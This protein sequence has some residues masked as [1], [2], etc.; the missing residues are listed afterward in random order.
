MGV[1]R[2]ILKN[3][4]DSSDLLWKIKTGAL[5]GHFFWRHFY[6]PVRVEFCVPVPLCILFYNSR[7]RCRWNKA[8]CECW[9]S[10]LVSTDG[11]YELWVLV[12]WKGRRIYIVF[13]FDRISLNSANLSWQMYAEMKIWQRQAPLKP[14]CHL[15]PSFPPFFYRISPCTFLLSPRPVSA[16]SFTTSPYFSLSYWWV[17]MPPLLPPEQTVCLIDNWKNTHTLAHIHSH[18]SKRN[19]IKKP[20][21]SPARD[22]VLTRL[23]VDE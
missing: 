5:S 20:L 17:Y 16:S 10:R 2:Y 9:Q 11:V 1:M 18:T 21:I 13:F 12:A 8:L 15:S 4:I 22:T 6:A 23:H 19:E 3:V 14:P 7:V